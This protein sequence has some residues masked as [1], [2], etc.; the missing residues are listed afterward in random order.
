MTVYIEIDEKFLINVSEKSLV[1]IVL[2]QCK[3]IIEELPKKKSSLIVG[4]SISEGGNYTSSLK[5]AGLNIIREPVICASL[6][7]TGKSIFSDLVG[8]MGESSITGSTTFKK[9]A[10]FQQDV[11]ITGFTRFKR[12]FIFSGKSTIKGRIVVEKSIYSDGILI[13]EGRL[14]CKRIVCNEIIIQGILSTLGDISANKFLF[15]QGRCI[16]S[17]NLTADEVIIK[18]SLSIAKKSTSLTTLSGITSYISRIFNRIF[19]SKFDITQ[20]IVEGNL[21]AKSAKLNNI[22]IYGD[23]I[24]D[25][26]IIGNDVEV[27]GEILYKHSISIPENENIIAH[28]LLE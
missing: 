2:E 28:K 7:S 23:L 9:D 11:T 17:G 3:P 18:P 12:H 21:K 10:I 24:A 27:Y 15:E 5:T 19:L 25:D 4:I 1:D 14:Q 13:A 26:L 6:V 16:I 8:V 20:I 22:L